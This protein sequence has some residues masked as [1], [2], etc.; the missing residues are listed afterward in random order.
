MHSCPNGQYPPIVKMMAWRAL[1]STQW[2][3]GD[4]VPARMIQGLIYVLELA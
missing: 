1:S 2:E 3:R 4:L